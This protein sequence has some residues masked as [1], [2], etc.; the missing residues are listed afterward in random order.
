MFN[1]KTDFGAIGDGAHPTEDTAAVVAALAALQINSSLRG[2]TVRW[3]T[4]YYNV[5]MEIAHAAYVAG[6]LHSIYHEGDGE[7]NTTID[8]SAAPGGSNGFSFDSGGHFGVSN[9]RIINAPNKGLY[10]TGCLKGEIE[11]LR[12]QACGDSGL[13]INSSYMTTIKS[14]WSRDNGVN[15][16]QVDGYNTSLDFNMISSSG[17][18]GVGQSYNGLTYSTLCTLASDENDEQG[19][20]FANCTGVAVSGIGAESNVKDMILLQAS[21]A[22]SGSV[23]LGAQDIHGLVFT[24]LA[25]YF[26]SFGNPGSYASLIH[27]KSEDG[28]PINF[29]VIGAHGTPNDPADI[30]FIFESDDGAIQCCR[31]LANLSQ[32]TARDLRILSGGG[33]A[34]CIND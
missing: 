3:P 11:N 15:G 17:N 23:P 10:A 18:T 29:K 26:N 33:S 13:H 16:V 8:F 9:L 19:Y 6:T 5:D 12:I 22:L 27:A 24:G 4:G 21:D 20:T 32:F 1:I 14:I 30:P 28:R 25:G 34:V 31:E 2:G 7:I